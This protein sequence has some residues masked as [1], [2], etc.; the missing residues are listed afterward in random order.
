MPPEYVFAPF[1]SERRPA[2]PL[3]TNSL[4][5]PD[6]TPFMVVCLLAPT[7]TTAVPPARQTGPFRTFFAEA[8]L[9]RIL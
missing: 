7:A 9:L 5:S 8:V 2:L 1:M 4:P 3:F 6:T